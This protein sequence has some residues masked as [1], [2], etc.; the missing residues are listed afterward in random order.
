MN[1]W[2]TTRSM[3]WLEKYLDLAAYQQ[4]L[5]AGNLANIDTPGFTAQG[6][7]FAAEMQRALAA[8]AQFEP[9]HAGGPRP[10]PRPV[11]G[12]EARP[13]GNNVSVDRES[14]LLAE[15]QIRFQ[16]GSQLLRRQFQSVR[17]VIQEGRGL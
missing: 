10:G 4:R 13:D 12:L 16:L 14:A 1:N 7:D 3:P 2:V 15:T 8:P 5:V 17:N 9:G 6:I 11:E